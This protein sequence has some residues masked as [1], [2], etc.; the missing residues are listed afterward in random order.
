M[1]QRPLLSGNVTATL[2][3]SVAQITG[4][5][6][7]NDFTVSLNNGSVPGLS[8]GT[9]TVTG[10]ATAINGA[11]SWNSVNP[12]TAIVITW[13]NGANGKETVNI[14]NSYASPLAGPVISIIQGNGNGD[15]IAVNGGSTS[16]FTAGQGNG[17]GDLIAVNGGSTGSF[18]AGQ[19][20]GN[21]DLIAVNGGSTGSF[22]T[23]Q[24]NGNGDLI[25]AVKGVS[26]GVFTTVQGNGNGNSQD[27]SSTTVDGS[28]SQ[29][30]GAGNGD[31]YTDNGVAATNLTATQAGSS[32]VDFFEALTV[33]NNFIYGGS[34]GGLTLN[35]GNT[36]SVTVGNEISLSTGG[37]NNFVNFGSANTSVT[38]TLLE[39]DFGTSS[40]D[41]DNTFQAENFMFVVQLSF[42]GFSDPSNL[43][44]NL[45]G[46]GP[47]NPPPGWSF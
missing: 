23:I 36:A 30:Q 37:A 24:G 2:V 27:I 7:H 3:G 20:N 10:V 46:N 22:T 11:G 47:V 6:G 15:L 39:L 14:V 16:V 8:N 1:E 19:G 4:D 45:G 13:P 9:I 38:A 28:V 44:I 12:V 21:G 26:T 33:G 41:I 5:F 18:T 43:Y 32:D 25:E 29:F 35:L 40:A 42:N 17:N 31:T 34:G